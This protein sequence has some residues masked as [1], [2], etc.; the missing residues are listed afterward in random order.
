MKKVC[1]FSGQ[2]FEITEAD[3]KFYEKLNVPPPTLC[4]DERMRRRLAFRNE[5]NLYKRECALCEKS[6]IS[7]YSPEK[8]FS[9]LCP[10]C[11]WSDKWDPFEYGRDFDFN[12]PFFEQFSELS[13]AIPHMAVNVVGNENCEYVSQTGYSKNCY[14][15]FNTDFSEDCLYTTTV[16]YSKDCVD[17]LNLD[18]C[19]LCFECIDSSHCYNSQF[20]QNCQNCSDS[21]FLKNCIGCH[22]CFGSV[23][24]RNKEYYFFNTSLSRPEWE[25]KIKNINLNSL[26][27]QQQWKQKFEEQKLEFPHKFAEIKNCENV[28]G[29][30]LRNCK[31]T[32]HCFDCFGN[33]DVK[34][35]ATFFDSKDCQ[36]Y[37]VGGYNAS[38]CYEMASGGYNV[39]RCVFSSHVWTNDQDIFYSLQGITSSKDLFGCVSLRN[40]QYCILNKQYSKEEY[41][42]L[43][44][45]IVE[46]MKKTGEWGE[47]FPITLSPFAY[48]ET[49]AQEYFPLT[50]KEALSRGYQWRDPDGKQYQA[51][52]YT[53]PENIEQVLDSV[54]EQLLACR[55][56]GKNY[57]IQKAE[58]KF[59]R[60][61]N[62]PIPQECPDCRHH[63]RMKLRNPR[64]LWQ[65]ECDQ[66]GT[67]I[68][69]TFAPDRPEEVSC[70]KCYLNSIN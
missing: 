34:H 14:L 9:L 2:E 12:C 44:E 56:C 36:D 54:C 70:E 32:Y 48:N 49:V 1:A 55:E 43:R 27:E 58:L 69:T 40:A 38:W 64:K 7:I 66:C 16:L 21:L 65:R 20:L 67:E 52:T 26:S 41:F 13:E 11:W 30:Y 24:L 63:N 57:K 10:D 19:E 51:Q 4:P 18:H 8:S 35:C 17:S 46:H 23:N 37:C 5:R 42:R 29:D 39:F 45:K 15:V 25:E 60:K 50:K 47:F 59:Y 31:N 6:V 28:T 53:I 68:Q 22:H 61:M 62:I 33:E 3:L